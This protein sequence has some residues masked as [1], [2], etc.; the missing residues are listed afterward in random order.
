MPSTKMSITRRV[1]FLI[2]TDFRASFNRHI[3]IRFSVL[4]YLNL[5][6]R[7]T[8]S[9]QEIDFGILCQGT[10]LNIEL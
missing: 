10:A 2:N 6:L 4:I 5:R 8:E 1:R 3:D 9:S 7:F